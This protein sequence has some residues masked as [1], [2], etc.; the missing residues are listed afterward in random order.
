MFSVYNTLIVSV[1]VLYGRVEGDPRHGPVLSPLLPG[2][3]GE[4]GE[5]SLVV[6]PGVLQEGGGG[7]RQSRGKNVQTLLMITTE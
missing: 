1:C 6:P 7:S 5:A 2:V 3:R 4:G